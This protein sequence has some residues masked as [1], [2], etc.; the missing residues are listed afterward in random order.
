VVGS[1]RKKVLSF[2]CKAMSLMNASRL[3]TGNSSTCMVSL[4]KVLLVGTVVV[5]FVV[6][7]VLTNTLESD[8]KDL[9][10]GSTLPIKGSFVSVV[11][12]A[13]ERLWKKRNK[14]FSFPPALVTETKDLRQQV[15]QA[16]LTFFLDHF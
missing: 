12:M 2:L 5:V 6:L 11:R 10:S 9:V 15:L 16:Q 7:S 1:D 13:N 4:V 14:V 8:I 3:L